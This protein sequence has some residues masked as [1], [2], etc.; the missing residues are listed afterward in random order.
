MS[1]RSTLA[2]VA[3]AVA[4]VGGSATAVALITTDHV[5][6]SANCDL[7]QLRVARMRGEVATVGGSRGLLVQFVNNGARC[8]FGGSFALAVSATTSTRVAIRAKLRG[9]RPLRLAPDQAVN[10]SFG[11]FWGNRCRAATIASVVFHSGR[12]SK[13]VSL[14]RLPFVFQICTPLYDWGLSVV[15]DFN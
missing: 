5:S 3:I 12:M 9:H 2:G 1:R 10:V 13:T 14:R 15:R 11:M 8:N 7:S 6:Q 4:L